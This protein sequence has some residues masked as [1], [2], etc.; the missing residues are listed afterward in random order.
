[1]SFY[2]FFKA[3][4]TPRDQGPSHSP[5]ESPEPPPP[6]KKAHISKNEKTPFET[7]SKSGAVRDNK[8]Q[9][10]KTALGRH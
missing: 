10:P 1:M 8:A 5:S 9:Y 7:L 4:P 6:A 3:V 2:N